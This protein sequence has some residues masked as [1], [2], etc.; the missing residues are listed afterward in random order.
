MQNQKD[1]LQAL[2]AA[3]AP[4]TECLN[5][6][7]DFQS[8]IIADTEVLG[9]IIAGGTKGIGSVEF[10][11]DL[12]MDVGS[13]LELELSGINQGQFDKLNVDG[14][15]SFEIGRTLRFQRSTQVTRKTVQTFFYRRS[16][17]SSTSLPRIRSPPSSSSLTPRPTSIGR[18]SPA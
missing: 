14:N 11:G 12:A 18:S 4:L 9:T 5:C 7:G 2:L 6:L 17:T 16:A 13:S 10:V 3:L 15:V 1:A 8:T